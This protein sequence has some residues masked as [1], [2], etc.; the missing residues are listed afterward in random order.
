MSTTVRPSVLLDAVQEA[1][2][3]AGRIALRYYRTSLEVMSKPDGSP[4]TIADRE[5]EAAVR[6][7]IERP[8]ALVEWIAEQKKANPRV[9]VLAA[10]TGWYAEDRGRATMEDIV[11]LMER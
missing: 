9:N 1:A 3:V 7:W 5:A 11:A 4:V 8:G 2:D 10:K 6:A